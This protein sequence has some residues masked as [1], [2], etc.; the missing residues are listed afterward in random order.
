MAILRESPW[1][2]EILKEGLQ[3]GKEQGEADLLIHLLSKR[4]GNIDQV[5]ESQIRQLPIT[6][7][8]ALGESLFDFSS[9]SDIYDWLERV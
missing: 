5:L 1:Y 3:Q 9:L 6:Q 7:I 4:F 8:E 2:Q